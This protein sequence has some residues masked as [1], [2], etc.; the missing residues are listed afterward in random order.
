MKTFLK[1][2]A[3]VIIL[4]TALAAFAQVAESPV[5]AKPQMEQKPVLAEEADD[6]D[7]EE[8]DSLNDDVVTIGGHINVDGIVE[9][10]V[11][12]IGGTF[13]VNAQIKGELVLIG[14]TGKIGPLTVVEQEFVMLGSRADIDT[15]AVF[16]GEKTNI[17]ING[18][19]AI[20]RLLASHNSEGKFT[21]ERDR[22]DITD[23]FNMLAAFIVMFAIAAAVIM[24]VK[25]H[26]RVESS[27]LES[28]LFI[29]LMG[30]LTEVLIIPAIILLAI[31]IVGIPFIPLFVLA[32]LAGLL[33]GWA[34][35]VNYT[36]KWI[37]E[38]LWKRELNPIMSV[39]V[40][41]AAFSI[42]P[43]IHNILNWADVNYLNTL[44][45]FLKYMQNYIIITFAFGGV[46]MSRFGST[47]FQKN[48]AE[49]KIEIIK[50]EAKTE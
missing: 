4:S 33:F 28:P 30:L 41:I 16:K 31:S 11:V 48:S 24:I 15:A 46:L 12:C 10:D 3:L 45:G 5:E 25:Q 17:Q 20:V 35:V 2:L 29:F 32:L 23:I 44:F 49:K 36:G 7:P 40:G 6:F 43:L 38:K 13:D 50:E 37:G 8:A 34:T 47:V 26:K 19:G 39:F 21:M 42:I 1:T 14:S 18:I 9:G 27:I 22:F